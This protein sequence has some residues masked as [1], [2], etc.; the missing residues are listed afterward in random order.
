MVVCKSGWWWCSLLDC[1][2][3]Q[4]ISQ[5]LSFLVPKG[6]GKLLMELDIIAQARNAEIP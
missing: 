2:L 4:A 1:P 3:V 5:S 6:S